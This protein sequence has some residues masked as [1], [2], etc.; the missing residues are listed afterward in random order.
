MRGEESCG[1]GTISTKQ[2]YRT[3]CAATGTWQR[4]CDVQQTPAPFRH[5]KEADHWRHRSLGCTIPN[6]PLG[7]DYNTA[8]GENGDAGR[9]AALNP[10]FD[11]WNTKRKSGQVTAGCIVAYGTVDW[12]FRE[13]KQSK[14]Y[15]EKVAPRSRPD[16]ERTM[17]LVSDII[18]KKGDRIGD[19]KIRAITPVAR[20][21]SMTSS[22]KGRAA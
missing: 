8:C 1:F 5:R 20:T 7:T 2:Y 9:A 16:Y 22:A 3:R 10:L 12:L 4:I 6:E 14:A 18:I 13:Y 15:L 11:E 17:L 21:E 19:R